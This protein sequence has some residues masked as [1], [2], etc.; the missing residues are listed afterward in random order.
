M[1]FLRRLLGDDDAPAPDGTPA[2]SREERRA[3]EQ[4]V[5]AER[6]TSTRQLEAGGLPVHAERRLRELRADRERRSDGDTFFTSDLTVDEFAFCDLDDLRPITQVMGSSIYHV[7]FQWMPSYRSWGASQELSTVS[8]AW[9]EAR[10]LALDRLVQEARLAG[11][12]AV[13]GV[14]LSRTAH[15]FASDGVE[16]IA[17][18]TAVELP[19]VPVP[20]DPPICDLGAQDFWKLRQAGYAPVGVLGHT[21]SFY[22]VASYQTQ[23][24][25]QGGRFFGGARNQELGDFTQ[26]MYDARALAMRSVRQQANALDAHGLV[27]VTV[28]QSHRVHKVST[29]NDSEREDLIVEFHVL[30]T[31][32]GHPGTPVSPTPT[33]TTVWL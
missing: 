25:M 5:E 8:H 22:I 9:N 30:G 1:G 31:A 2:P 19:G 14:R 24:A 33:A 26:G 7:G 11:A 10:R 15:A 29:G 16:W 4:A 21:T 17:T 28:E 27:G 12:H 3:R 13:V 18:G 20:A 6:E 23:R 32:I